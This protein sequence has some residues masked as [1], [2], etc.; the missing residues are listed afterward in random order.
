MS[1]KP[2]IYQNKEYKEFHNNKEVYMSSD[3]SNNINNND[4]DILK[5]SND[6]RKKIND[7]IN[8]SSFIYLTKVNIAINNDIITRKIV[9]IHNNNLITIDNEYIPIDNIKDIYK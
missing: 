1:E 9:G 6:I 4:S 7:I 5:N 3:R 8:S 2:K